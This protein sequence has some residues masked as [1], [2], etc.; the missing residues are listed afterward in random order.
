MADSPDPHVRLTHA[1]EQLGATLAQLT[2][3]LRSHY[4]QLRREGFTPTQAMDLV[5]ALQQVLL[6][7]TQS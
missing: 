6:D 1:L 5:V 7:R 4:D 2:P 3:V